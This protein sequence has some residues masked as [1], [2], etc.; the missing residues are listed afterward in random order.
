MPIEFRRRNIVGYAQNELKSGNSLVGAQFMAIG[1][2]AGMPL[3]SV[4]PTGSD[5][6]DNVYLSTLDALGFT[7][8]TYSWVNWAGDNG[9]QEAW[10]DDDFAIVEDV[11]FAPGAAVWVQASRS[12]QGV[13][14]AGQVGS[15]DVVVKLRSGNTAVANPFPV[16]VDLQDIL[17]TGEG[18]SDNVY[19]STLDA[20]G[21]TIKT[22]SWVN[23]AGDNGD[24]EAW[25]DDDF[26]IVE[27]VK[28]APGAGLWVQ[29]SSGSQG[30]RI[31]A[32]EL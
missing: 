20:L 8:T 3:Q 4:K 29:G 12:E 14:T 11:T 22:Y 2:D 19:A 25:I 16:A 6:S 24:Q 1:S 7:V 10:I 21:Y 27:G 13:Q 15:S 5:T 23:W 31:P 9:D 17:P 32:P 30:I 28:I 26:A 18:T